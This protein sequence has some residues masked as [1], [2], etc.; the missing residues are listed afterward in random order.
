MM[1]Q[2]EVEVILTTV[3]K[4]NRHEQKMSC[5]EEIIDRAT[6]L[7][8]M[9]GKRRQGRQRNRWGDEISNFAGDSMS[10]E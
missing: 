6:E 3:K 1:E 7:Q 2:I 8:P 5:A 4:T 10:G 9:D